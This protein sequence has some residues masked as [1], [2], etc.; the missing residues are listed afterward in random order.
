M[1]VF[2]Y[3]G[4]VFLLCDLHC[5][6]DISAE[7][8]THKGNSHVR[9]W[10][11]SPRSSSER[12]T[13]VRE[14]DLRPETNSKEKTK[15]S[16]RLVKKQ[17][18]V[19][20]SNLQ[21]GKRNIRR[22]N[23]IYVKLDLA[24]GVS[25]K[26]FAQT[27]RNEKAKGKA[28]DGKPATIQKSHFTSKAQGKHIDSHSK[29]ATAKKKKKLFKKYALYDYQPIMAGG[30][31]SNT[32]YTTQTEGQQVAYVKDQ[33]FSPDE[34]QQQPL[35]DGN[36]LIQDDAPQDVAGYQQENS[37]SSVAAF[38]PSNND[39]TSQNEDG[40]PSTLEQAIQ[41]Q[42]AAYTQQTQEQ[43]Q[44]QDTTSPSQD[45][46]L[47]GQGNQMI[48][49][50]QLQYQ[51]EQAAQGQDQ[52]VQEQAQAQSSF[53]QAGYQ[54]GQPQEIDQQS[55]QGIDQQQQDQTQEYQQQ[56]QEEQQQQP[57]EESQ[58]SEGTSSDAQS[59]ATS[60]NSYGSV[61]NTEGQQTAPEQQGGTLSYAT[62]Q[63]SEAGDKTTAPGVQYASSIEEALKEPAV[64]TQETN[65]DGG[66]N[67]GSVSAPEGANIIN[68]GPGVD[69]K[70]DGNN[71]LEGGGSI[72]APTGYQ[73][74]VVDDNG[75]PLQ[76]GAGTDVTGY[77]SS[78]DQTANG[79]ATGFDENQQGK[80]TFS[81]ENQDEVNFDQQE[82]LQ[83][84]PSQKLP[85][86]D[87]NVYK[88]ISVAN[89]NGPAAGKSSLKTQHTISSSCT[90][91]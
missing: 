19:P 5:I 78:Y 49:G 6:P 55:P 81:S 13:N 31:E 17:D 75:N 45:G 1:K 30:D 8:Q 76:T 25:K 35:S 56:Q 79:A 50:G 58:G 7:T 88:I 52:R 59:L 77:A 36:S 66:E 72:N 10:T 9:Q 40:Q 46:G 18:G 85:P 82:S 63:S 34:Q 11:K 15:N 33:D 48:D 42:Q 86:L 32:D 20:S 4:L 69:S 60:P 62:E 22:N 83:Q 89:Q 27:F 91:L 64:P 47:P 90:P 2:I 65:S 68:I 43:G 71:G 53:E 3:C 37:Q 61:F 57:V 38:V 70:Q 67:Q 28:I 51:S 44:D 39:D 87:D 24:D 80:G 23:K 21:D 54:Q 84:G 29:K 74:S 26:H 12:T 73:T 16:G 41:L 14:K